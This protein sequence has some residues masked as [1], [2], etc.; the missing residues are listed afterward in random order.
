MEW[1]SANSRQTPW[2]KPS[3]R[4][5]DSI[6]VKFIVASSNGQGLVRIRLNKKTRKNFIIRVHL[7]RPLTPN[8]RGSIPFGATIASF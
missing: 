5:P 6:L 1:A 8:K 7:V 3:M 2:G 4:S